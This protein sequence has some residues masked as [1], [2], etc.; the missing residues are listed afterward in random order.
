MLEI[1]LADYRKKFFVT[2]GDKTTVLQVKKKLAEVVS[3]PAAS[4]LIV[5]DVE[6]MNVLADN[7][8]LNEVVSSQNSRLLIV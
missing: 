1:L 6:N 8:I 7:L 3:A 2:P 4:D 5:I